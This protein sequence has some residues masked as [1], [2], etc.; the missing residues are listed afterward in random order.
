MASPACGLP[1][2]SGDSAELAAPLRHYDPGIV[3]APTDAAAVTAAV[4]RALTEPAWLAA[5]RAGANR[6]VA[7]RLAWDR[8]IAHFRKYLA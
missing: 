8:T 5:K 1:P 4:T 6:L 7:E 3:V 2:R